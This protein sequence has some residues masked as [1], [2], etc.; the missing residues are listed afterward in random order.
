MEI[1]STV[2]SWASILR[3]QAGPHRRAGVWSG[4]RKGHHGAFHPFED[5]D[6]QQVD[7][8]LFAVHLPEETFAA[9]NLRAVFFV[10]SGLFVR[11][12]IAQRRV[13][14]ERQAANLVVDFADGAEL[15]RRGPRHA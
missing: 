1:S 10:V 7:K 12:H 6:P 2:G 15:P 4:E 14:A 5:V 11:Q 13:G 3:E 8:A 9:A